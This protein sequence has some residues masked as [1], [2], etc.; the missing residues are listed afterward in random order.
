MR[1]VCALAVEWIFAV[2]LSGSWFWSRKFNL[3][4]GA[5]ALLS[6]CLITSL[7]YFSIHRGLRRHVARI[8]SLLAEAPFPLD[9]LS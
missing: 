1:V 4:W 8:H 2:L 3:T 6:V 7:C 5:I 9:S